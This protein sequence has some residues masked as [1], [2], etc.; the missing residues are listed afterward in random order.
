MAGTTSAYKII[1]VGG[2]ELGM[3]DPAGLGPAARAP[4]R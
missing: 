3:R 4:E 2:R 1:D